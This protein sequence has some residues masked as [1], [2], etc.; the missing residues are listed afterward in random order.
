MRYISH[1][2]NL[3]GPNP[4]KENTPH[5]IKTA[6]SKGFEVEVDI[7]NFNGDFYLGHDTAE[8]KIEKSFLLDFSNDLWI[9][10]KN[11]D[12][13]KSCIRLSLDDHL[14]YFWH[15]KDRY[16]L[17]SNGWVISYPGKDACT[18]HGLCMIPERNHPVPEIPVYLL[19]QGFTA[20]C[21][22][23]IENIKELNS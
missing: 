11:L 10:C 7:W 22:D 2:G 17:T 5:Y 23:Y 4:D 15:E 9:H 19:T 20:V 1:R 21:S 18:P 13:L 12:A 6:M 8:Y 14:N 3:T 16:A